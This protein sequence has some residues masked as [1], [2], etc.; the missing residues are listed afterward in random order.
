MIRAQNLNSAA[1]CR[2]Q[3][4]PAD[5]FHRCLSQRTPSFPASA[6][7]HAA[8]RHP[9]LPAH[10]RRSR[11]QSCAIANP[12]VGEL[13]ATRAKHPAGRKGHQGWCR[14]D[15]ELLRGA[16]VPASMLMVR[17]FLMLGRNNERVADERADTGG[18]GA[19]VDP[20]RVALFLLTSFQGFTVPYFAIPHL[21]PFR[22][23]PQLLHGVMFWL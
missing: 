17:I 8:R 14:E 15:M 20:D 2:R 7:P 13:V 3:E 4:N 5:P 22:S 9:G 21:G 10:D 18:T 11:A 6:D 16:E 12:I 19:S 23:H 1:D